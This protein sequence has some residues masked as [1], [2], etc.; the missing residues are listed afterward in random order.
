MRKDYMKK[1]KNR[2]TRLAGM[3]DKERG[4]KK[5]NTMRRKSRGAERGGEEEQ[6]EEDNDEE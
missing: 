6:E 1:G 2:K 4:V 3:K 5:M